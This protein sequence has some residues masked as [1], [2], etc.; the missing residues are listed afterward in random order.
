MTV[1]GEPDRKRTVGRS[2]HR[3][4]DNIKMDLKEIECKN[5]DWIHLKQVAGFCEHHNELLN[6]IKCWEFL[7]W[8]SNYWLFKEDSAPWS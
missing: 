1:V 3:W 8:L 5:V 6:S 2:R 7:E 4:E